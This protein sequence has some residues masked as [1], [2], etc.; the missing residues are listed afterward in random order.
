MATR[1]AGSGILW[2]NRKPGFTIEHCCDVQKTSN[3]RENLEQRSP[4]LRH[5]NPSIP[6]GGNRVAGSASSHTPASRMST[7]TAMPGMDMTCKNSMEDMGDMGPSMAAMVGHMYNTPLRPQQPGD[8]DKSQRRG[9]QTKSHHGRATR[10][11]A[12]L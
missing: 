4:F 1:M 12:R 9:R 10:T 3:P 8:V 6:P 2:R 11:T 7:R 5:S